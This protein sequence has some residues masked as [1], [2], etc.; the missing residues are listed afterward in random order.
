MEGLTVRKFDWPGRP[1]TV[2][3][4]TVYLG[5]LTGHSLQTVEFNEAE[6]NE[7]YRRVMEEFAAARVEA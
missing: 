6:W 2:A 4:A 1:S 7:V 5:K 3:I